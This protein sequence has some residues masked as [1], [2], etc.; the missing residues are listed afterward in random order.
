ME[1]D[2]VKQQAERVSDGTELIG[3]L[4]PTDCYGVLFPVSN[5]IPFV[6]NFVQQ[7]YIVRVVP[8]RIGQIENLPE[9]LKVFGSDGTAV[10]KL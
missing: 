8:P 1:V 2:V 6:V 5:A 7:P 10:G 4:H 3:T 9:S